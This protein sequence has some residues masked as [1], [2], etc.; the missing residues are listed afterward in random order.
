MTQERCCFGA[1]AFQARCFVISR[2]TLDMSLESLPPPIANGRTAEIYPWGEGQVLKLYYDWFSIESIQFE[3]WISRAVHTSGIPSPAVGEIVQVNGRNGL[4]YQ[5]V[6]GSSMLEKLPRKLWNLRRYARRMAELHVEMHTHTVQVNLPAQHDRLANKIGRARAL[7][8]D[9]RTRCLNALES[10]PGGDRLCHNDFHPDNILLTEH[11][12][13]IIDWGDA[14][15]GNPIADVARTSIIALGAA[16][17]DQIPNPL[18]RLSFRLFHDIYL[19]H[20][21][22]LQP[23]TKSEYREWMPIVAAARLSEDIPEVENWLLEQV[24]RV[25]K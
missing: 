4:V 7:P 2:Y 23:G 25:H 14:A 6:N 11:G 24:K 18:H 10:M 5:R 9:Q 21:F 22:S 19:R 8:N 15:L 12:E 17:T 3:Q 20:Y 1:T 13:V 16:S